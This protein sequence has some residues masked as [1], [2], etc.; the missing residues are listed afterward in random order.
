MDIIAYGMDRS[1]G[2]RIMTEAD[3]YNIPDER[4]VE[5]ID[6]HIYDMASPG[7]IHQTVF[8]ELFYLISDYIRKKGG[9]CRVMPDLDT[10]LDTDEDTIVRPDISVIC[11]P[12][13]LT[14]RRCEGSPDWIIEIVSP[15]NARND[16]LRKLELY[17]RVGVREYW[18]VD[19]MKKSVIVY[20]FQG[21]DL[22]MTPYCFDD[23]ITPNIYKDLIIDF[24]LI[25]GKLDATLSGDHV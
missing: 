6:G 8:G 4:R 10:K 20:V 25:D 12:D 1:G 23:K 7:V 3:Y 14:D 2:E 17:Q 19:P 21:E 16:Y 9:R 13:K 11:D 15:G 22:D 5:L 18:I 24:S